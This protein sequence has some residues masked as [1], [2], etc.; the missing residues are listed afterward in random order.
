VATAKSGPQGGDLSTSSHA[1]AETGSGNAR[2]LG[3]AT[4]DEASETVTGTVVT[5]Q[6]DQP[7]QTKRESL[8]T[9]MIE[10][11]QAEGTRTV[12]TIPVGQI[13]NN[14]PI[15]TVVETWYSPQLQTVVYSKTTDP[16]MGET[17]YQ[18]TKIK[19]SEP[20]PSLLQL[21]ADARGGTLYNIKSTSADTRSR[22]TAPK[23]TR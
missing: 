18:L 11:V 6:L 9:K 3:E 12:M 15:Q 17:V 10:G 14:R 5:Y 8:G 19:L 13:G 7:E 22:G 1:A 2:K 21:P 23:P 4:A 16:R 20:E